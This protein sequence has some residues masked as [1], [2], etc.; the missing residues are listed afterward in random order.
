MRRVLIALG[1]AVI[2]LGATTACFLLLEPTLGPR[3]AFWPGGAVQWL[4]EQFGVFTTN[5]IHL[6]VTLLFWWLAAWLVLGAI[7]RSKHAA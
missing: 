6:W 5:R 3:F 7:S 2:I 1:V 4:L